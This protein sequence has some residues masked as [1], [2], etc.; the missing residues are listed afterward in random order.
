MQWTIPKNSSNLL[1]EKLARDIHKK[2]NR[3]SNSNISISYG[4]SILNLGSLD[5]LRLIY[6][7][8]PRN[9][10]ERIFKKF[11]IKTY[12]DSEKN[13]PGSGFI[14]VIAFLKSCIYQK[15]LDDSILELTSY[16]K[17]SRRGK[18]KDLLKILNFLTS[19]SDTLE[20]CKQIISKGGFNSSCDIETSHQIFDEIYVDNF[21][22]FNVR[23]DHDFSLITKIEDISHQNA[24]FIIADGIIESVS[25][26]HHV[27]EYYNSNKKTC[28]IVCRGYEPE[29]INT[30]SKNYLRNSLKV[31]PLVLIH[32]LDSINTLK[33]LSVISG[34]NLI[35]NLKGEKISSIDTKEICSVEYARCSLS[36]LEIRNQKNSLEILK[37]INNLKNNLEKERHQDVKDILQKRISSL[38]PRKI[39]IKLSNHK[40]DTV[41]LK[42]DRVKSIVSIIN[43]TCTF[44]IISLNH[45]LNDKLLVDIF[46]FFKKQKFKNMPAM[47]FL[48]GIKCGI[49]NSK[50]FKNSQSFILL[51]N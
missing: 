9:D 30:L 7:S 24:D 25:E 16:S 13:C 44:G 1:Q 22:N 48:E 20:I 51:D 49:I 42:K 26:I 21:H 50:I 32:N 8:V 43:S 27:L 38:S 18:E 47:C 40:K 39:N 19:D 14:S 35:S 10:S 29:V 36:N 41:G 37:L 46:N 17:F 31:I 33:D 6:E 11:L 15:N 23:L 45:E 34:S 12:S 4:N 3:L 28:F 2:I 5:I